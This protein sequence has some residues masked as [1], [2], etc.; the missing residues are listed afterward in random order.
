MEN[1]LM[2]KMMPSVNNRLTPFDHVHFKRLESKVKW[3]CFYQDLSGGAI[4]ENA[5]MRVRMGRSP[6]SLVRV[7]LRTL[8][9]AWGGPQRFG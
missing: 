6:R 1:F 2:S 9:M 5:A 7:V 4:N 3:P 8:M